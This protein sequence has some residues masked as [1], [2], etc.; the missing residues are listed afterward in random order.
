MDYEPSPTVKPHTLDQR[1]VDI[2][3]EQMLH[4]NKVKLG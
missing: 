1:L 2:L 4:D 3:N